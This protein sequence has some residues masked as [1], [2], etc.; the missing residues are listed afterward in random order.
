MSYFEEESLSIML[1]KNGRKVSGHKKEGRVR[2]LGCYVIR[3]FVVYILPSIDMKM[4]YRMLQSSL[5]HCATNQKV[6]C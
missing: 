2:K 3:N 4:K 5:R 6:A 1:R